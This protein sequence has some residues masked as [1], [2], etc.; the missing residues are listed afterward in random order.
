MIMQSLSKDDESTPTLPRNM[1]GA[2]TWKT[3]S[4]PAAGWLLPSGVTLRCCNKRPF[5]GSFWRS[6]V[7][8]TKIFGKFGPH[9]FFYPEVVDFCVGMFECPI[10][11]GGLGNP[12]NSENIP[13]FSPILPRLHPFLYRAFEEPD[14][15]RTEG[16]WRCWTVKKNMLF[17]QRWIT[18]HLWNRSYIY[19]LYWNRINE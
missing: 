8:P 1:V 15:A 4:H 9:F 13:L 11:D 19:I 2:K 10:Q 3:K 12:N 7:T 18:H 6:K 14:T 17:I 5:F 16:S